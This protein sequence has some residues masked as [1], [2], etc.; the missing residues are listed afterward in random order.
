MSNQSEI[1]PTPDNKEG[2]EA[3]NNS[4]ESADKP[5]A[6]FLVR[7][8]DILILCIGLG[9]LCVSYFTGAGKD[10]SLFILVIISGLCI[11]FGLLGLAVRAVIK[12]PRMSLFI[13]LITAYHTFG[14]SAFVW[15]IIALF[16][17]S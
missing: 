14:V 17:M 2:K 13:A 9:C 12:F 8:P 5:Q 7:K 15:I 16:C 11:A 3:P 4:Q 1:S 6:S 10:K